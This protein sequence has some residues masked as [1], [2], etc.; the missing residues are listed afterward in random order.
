M[1]H[2]GRGG[3]FFRL[4]RAIRRPGLGGHSM[5]TGYRVPLTL[6]YA[7][8]GHGGS[9]VFNRITS[10]VDSSPI[11]LGRLLPA[12]PK[13]YNAPTFAPA[14]AH[15]GPGRGRFPFPRC[16]LASLVTFGGRQCPPP[17]CHR[18][19]GSSSRLA[20]RNA[21]TLQVRRLIRVCTHR[22]I[23][24]LKELVLFAAGCFPRRHQEAQHRV[25][26][27]KWGRQRK[28]KKNALNP[29]SA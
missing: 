16:C 27:D 19:P 7:A 2:T 4:R 12:W 24:D 11:R 6:G 23:R 14:V 20:S 9:C 15:S 10:W 5:V 18:R 26:Y 29:V 8:G 1:S 21:F 17:S 13:I 25:R 22:L 28:L 3:S